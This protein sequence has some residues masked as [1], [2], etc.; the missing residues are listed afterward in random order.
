MMINDNELVGK[1]VERKRRTIKARFELA[2]FW[3]E[4]HS[5]NLLTATLCL[6]WQ[7]NCR[8]HVNTNIQ[9]CTAGCTWIVTYSFVL[10]AAREY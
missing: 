9:F 1:D 4:N 3:Y 2:I 10:Q 6:Q 5:V 8:L 7:I